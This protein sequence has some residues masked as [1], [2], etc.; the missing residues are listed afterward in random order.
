MLRQR[1]SAGVVSGAVFE[2]GYLAAHH[3]RD[4]VS[5]AHDLGAIC[6]H[7]NVWVR[8]KGFQDSPRSRKDMDA[9]VQGRG[10]I[11]FLF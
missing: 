4:A 11:L 2:R 8:T 5:S 6:E 7:E 10:S 1:Q 9:F 3:D